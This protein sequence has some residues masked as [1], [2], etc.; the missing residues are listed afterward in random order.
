MKRVCCQAADGQE[1]S[2]D[3]P[4]PVSTA[5]TVI[6]DG[7]LCSAEPDRPDLPLQS[8]P[9]QHQSF[10]RQDPPQHTPQAGTRVRPDPSAFRDCSF[11]KTNYDFISK[12]KLLIKNGIC[13]YKPYRELVSIIF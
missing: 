13:C 4:T 6:N 10:P 12:W 8:V 5:V 3:S 9:D 7:A 11:M 1:W 2:S